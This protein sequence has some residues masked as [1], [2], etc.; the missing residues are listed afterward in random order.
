MKRLQFAF[1]HP[2]DSVVAGAGRERHVGERGIYAGRGSHAGA[3]GKEKIF[4]V[5]GL[6]VGIEDGSF[7]VTAHARGTHFMNGQTGRAHFRGD[8]DVS[9]S[10]HGEHL[11][12]LNGRIAEHG[13]LVFAPLH[14]NLERGN[15]P[16]IEFV[17]VDFGVVGVVG[18][19]GVLSA[20][21]LLLLLLLLSLL[22]SVSTVIGCACC[23]CCCCCCSCCCC[24]PF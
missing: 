19:V 15:T 22:A 13:A 8:G 5:V 1:L 2:G 16:G 17:F 14:M 6:I 7:G 12:G 21:L 4:Y 3:I 20:P 23:C 11:G 24:G 18:V 9:G 10:G